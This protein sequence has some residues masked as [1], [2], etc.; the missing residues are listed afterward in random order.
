MKILLGS[1]GHLA[2][3]IKT[4]LQILMG[5]DANK[6][7]VID[8]YVDDG[9]IDVELEK[10]FKN[11]K[12]DEKVLMMSDLYGGSVNQKMYLY[13]QRPN[14]YLVAGVNLAL[15]IELCAK[16]DVDLKELKEITESAK[17]MMRI[18]ELTANKTIQDDEDF[19]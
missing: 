17:D 16:E 19:L 8:A 2:S 6:V 10:F 3:G 1:H 15:V 14:T 13:L 4:S 5:E 9:N 11:V 12:E 7:T 18:V